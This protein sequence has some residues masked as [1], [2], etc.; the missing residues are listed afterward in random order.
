M[1][2]RRKSLKWK[3]VLLAMLVFGSS[4]VAGFAYFTYQS[5]WLNVDTTL[6]GMMNFTDAKQQGVISFLEQNEK[7]ATQLANLADHADFS[8]LRY[9]F[10]NIVI[11]DVFRL[12]QHPFK[13]EIIAGTRKIPTWNAYHAIDYV[14]HGVIIISSDPRREGTQWNK[15]VKPTHGYSDPYYDGNV[16]VMTFAAQTKDGTVYVNADA[17]MLTNI[18][19]GEIGN[20]AG[21][22]G[23]YYLVGVGKTL[24][25]Y[26]V[27]RQ[28]LLVTESRVRPGQFLKGNGS[29]LPWRTTTQQA[30]IMCGKRGVYTTNARCITGC[31]EVMGFYIGQSGKKMLGASMPFYDSGWTIV[32]EEEA[33][34]LLMPMWIMFA[35]ASGALLLIGVLASFLFSNLLEKVLFRPLKRLQD[36]IEDV[37]KT[38]DFSKLI[39]TESE[40]EIGELA[41]SYNHMI[42]NLRV[43]YS[44]LESRIDARTRELTRTN[45]QLRV[46]AAAFETH[47][48]IMIT[49]AN[50]NIIRVN[51]AFQSITGFTANEVVGKNP[52]IL[53]SGCHSKG[54][55][56]DMWQQLLT[57]GTWTGEILDRRKNGEIYPHWMTITAVRDDAGKTT[58][59]VSIFSDITARKNAEDEI[60]KLAFSDPLTKL[61]NRRLLKDRLRSALSVSAR[62]YHYG[63]VMFLDMDKFKMLNDT[64]GHDFGDLLLVEVAMR[65]KHCLREID[66][67]ARLGGDEF[68]VIIE[69]LGESIE[70]ASNKIAQ[71]AEKIRVSLSSPY[72]LKDNEHHCSSS[73]GVSLFRG[74]EQSA[75]VLLKQADLAMYQAKDSG[76]NAVRFYDPTMQQSVEI[77]AAL[78]A[79]LRRALPDLQLQLHYQIQVDNNHQPLGAEALLRW[80]HPDRGL[81]SPAQFI[82]IAEE[83]SLILDM[84]AWVLEAACRQLAVWAQSDKT[85]HL[86]LAVNVSA[87]QFKQNDFVEQVSSELKAYHVDPSRLKIELTESV[88]LNNVAD[89]IS[90]MHALRAIGVS[91]SLDDFGT[92]YSSL[93]YLKQLPLDQIKIDQSFV[94]DIVIDSKDAMMIKTIID[95]AQNFSLNVI[96]EGVETEDQLEFLKQKGCMAYQGYF[97]GKPV[98][99]EEFEALLT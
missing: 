75:T 83:S 81:V 64:L 1:S 27:N 85:R 15:I 44:S 25:Y 3:I 36:A 58:E 96:A 84:G 7:L 94:R 45:E 8:T 40:G 74:H 89:V 97:F 70:D 57:I 48:G 86:I 77:R 98:P 32:V 20:M 34:E 52:R 68:V 26:I 10:Q 41:H 62:N 49:D 30:G 78:E 28:N 6:K 61:P 43:L 88:V 31:R 59:Y 60:R 2:I 71:I 56:V 87:H 23:A 72:Q 4:L 93:S 76:R 13:G 14:R 37:E 12:E 47:E 16:P 17:R 91:L 51:Q 73:I 18:V 66:T 63:A 21:G 95:M 55:Y 24:D 53:S 33:N 69:E 80:I 5:Y 54:F 50:N 19:S 35:Y 82:P 11:T 65:I 67:V 92:G 38:C 39:N 90:K 22:M 29:E 79:D 46:T 42:E 99:I 9:Q